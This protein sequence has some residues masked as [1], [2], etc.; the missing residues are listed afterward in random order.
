MSNA[1]TQNRH[2]HIRFDVAEYTISEP[3]QAHRRAGTE[4]ARSG[5][6]SENS[7]NVLRMANGA[8]SL[9]PIQ[10]TLTGITEHE[11]TAGARV[12]LSD[13]NTI[14]N[15]KER[16]HY[17]A[18]SPLVGVNLD[19]STVSEG[20]YMNEKT[21]GAGLAG[22]FAQN[23]DADVT[24]REQFLPGAQTTTQDRHA[25]ST[26]VFDENQA[27]TL[28]FRTPTGSAF[29]A[30][31]ICK[32]FGGPINSNG[33]GQYAIVFMGALAFLAEYSQY[34]KDQTGNGWV[35]VDSWQYL[36][37]VYPGQNVTVHIRPIKTPKGNLLLE[38][39]G[40]IQSDVGNSGNTGALILQVKSAPQSITTHVTKIDTTANSPAAPL[41]IT[42]RDIVTGQGPVRIEMPS[43]LRIPWQVSIWKYLPTGYFTD[44]PVTFPW[45]ISTR[46]NIVLYWTADVPA[47]CAFGAQLMDVNTRSE[48]TPTGRSGAGWKEYFVNPNQPNYYTVF[49]LGSDSEQKRTPVLYEY[50][51]QRNAEAVLSEPGEFILPDD[52]PGPRV[53]SVSI[54]G[55]EADPTHETAAVRISDLTGDLGV[56]AARASIRTRIETEYDPAHPELRS[57]LFD[58]Y[59]Q[60]ATG[61]RRGTSAAAGFGG[62]GVSR[63]YPSRFWRDFECAFVGMW[64]RLHRSLTM[65]RLDLQK[66]D[67]NADIDPDTGVAPPLKVTDILRAL[68]GYVGFLPGQIDVPDSPIRFYPGGDENGDSLMID[69]LSNVGETVVALA[70]KYLGWFLI[71]DGNA[72]AEGGMWR[73]RPPVPTYG[74]Y[75]NLAAF[76]LDGAGAGKLPTVSQSYNGNTAGLEWVGSVEQIPTLYIQK[77]TFTSYPIPPEGNAVCV[78]ATG[79]YLPSNGVFQKTNWICN[80]KSYDFFVGSDGTPIHTADPS[81][82]D[83]LGFFAPI[84]VVNFGLFTQHAVNVVC[85]R[86]YDVSCH[87]TKI[88]NFEA[89]LALVVDP[90]DTFQSAPRPLRYYDPVVIVQDG[91]A[92]QWLV[93]NCNP[94][95]HKDN[96]Q[97]AYYELQAPFTD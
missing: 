46:A 1:P 34:Q 25:V 54:S 67:P 87:G 40:D 5:L 9:A 47:G 63:P 90:N 13:F 51:L 49:T 82:P 23:L 15:Y 48:L 97:Y 83:Y 70:K 78:T 80:G 84:I 56:L 18:P 88:A 16:P 33:N 39:T 12:P 86:I 31:Q 89:P 44:F 57:V 32:H 2:T 71:W 76:T 81:H 60:K 69:P 73:I 21:V 61:N 66:S 10:K 94:T 59:L 95:Y 92:S 27:F 62:G 79:Q 6:G 93:R 96:I 74:P 37:N 38:F 91:E 53:R 7:S 85:R 43:E 11:D 42:A 20:L 64:M 30:T 4:M 36:N 22:G 52:L 50:S 26:V 14:P 3:A 24:A 17:R 68:L 41:F 29:T 45:N 8:I 65:F 28:R 72:G 35:Q 75:I 19:P 58:G 55:P 77:G